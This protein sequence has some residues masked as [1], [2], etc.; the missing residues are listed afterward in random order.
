MVRIVQRL[1]NLRSQSTVAFLSFLIVWLVFSSAAQSPATTGLD[2]IRAEELRQKL[3]YI[4]SEKFKV[5]G[6]GTLELNMAADYIAGVF[7]KNGVQP[8]GDTGTYYQRF[9]VYSSRLGSNNELRIHSSSASLD[10]KARSDFIPE[11]WSVS[12]TVTGPLELVEDNRSGALRLDGKIAVELEDR[13]VSDDPEFPTNATEG[14]KLEAAG[15]I[16]A[17]IV[18]TLRNNK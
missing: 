14:R 4:A 13:I 2:S 11:L 6:N 3:T 1:L 12:G 5:R 10:L 7:E 17:I 16:G 18:Q 9:N 8:A 15:A